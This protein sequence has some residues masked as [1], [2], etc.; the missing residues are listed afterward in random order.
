MSKELVVTKAKEHIR[1]SDISKAIK[2][3]NS[4]FN[5]DATYKSYAQDLIEIE[6]QYNK[7]SRERK[8]GIISYEEYNLQYNRLIDQLNTLLHDF[9]DHTSTKQETP[10]PTYN[11]K[12]ML[13]ALAVLFCAV[14]TFNEIRKRSVNDRETPT[15]ETEVTTPPSST[16]N[17]ISSSSSCPT[18]DKEKEFNILLFPFLNHSDDRQTLHLNI[19]SRLSSFSQSHNLKTSVLPYE[20]K[21]KRHLLSTDA[22]SELAKECDANLIIWGTQEKEDDGYIVSAS[23]QFV[24]IEEYFTLDQIEINSS[25]NTNL[26]TIPSITD[27]LN[28]GTITKDIENTISL[29]LLG[30]AAYQMEETEKAIALLRKF[31]APDKNT[32]L[33]QNKILADAYLNTQQDEAAIKAYS[34]VLKITPNDKLSRINRAALNNKKGE[35]TAAMKD[36]D[37]Q[38]QQT[39]KDTEILMA[40]VAINLQQDYLNLSAEDINTIHKISPNLSNPQFKALLATQKKKENIIKRKRHKAEIELKKQ[41]NNEKVLLELANTSYLLS[42]YEQA[43]KYGEAAKKQNQKNAATLQLC[44]KA[45]QKLNIDASEEIRIYNALSPRTTNQFNN[46]S[47]QNINQ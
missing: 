17:G 34:R 19:A 37:Q 38:L 21:T 25:P 2:A 30:V 18:F 14:I 35:Y 10:S 43:L 9:E 7:F 1:N 5:Q 27:I 4:F 28:G 12:P 6:S 47:I 39:P 3:L 31:K 32:A 15:F 36:L 13:I 20:N 8:K 29:L 44:I 23:Y 26:T 11:F 16:N 42:E 45:K 33:L 41:P 46:I 40:K 24:D 22:A